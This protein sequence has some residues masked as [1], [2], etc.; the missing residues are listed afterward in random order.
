MNTSGYPCLLQSSALLRKSG[1]THNRT[2]LVRFLFHEIRSWGWQEDSSVRAL[3]YDVP[4]MLMPSLV[5]HMVEGGHRVNFFW[6]ESSYSVSCQVE[7]WGPIFVTGMYRIGVRCVHD[8][9]ASIRVPVR[10]KISFSDPLEVGC[11]SGSIL[12][13]IGQLGLGGAFLLTTVLIPRQNHNSRTAPTG[14]P[15]TSTSV[16]REHKGIVTQHHIRAS[17]EPY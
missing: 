9:L 14:H 16:G 5:T 7:L 2:I 13:F 3:L 8:L 1:I 17:E 11:I 15:E 6:L 4:G 10:W 12:A